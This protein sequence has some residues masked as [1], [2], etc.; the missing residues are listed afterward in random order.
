VLL[1]DVLEHFPNE[2]Q[3]PLLAAI[4][5]SLV[6][7]GRLIVKTPNANSIVASRWRYTRRPTLRFW[8]SKFFVTDW[9]RFLIR[10]FWLQ[11]FKAEFPQENLAPISF[12]ANLQA[13][14]HKAK[15][16]GGGQDNVPA[17]ALE[18][19]VAP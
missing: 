2:Q 9:R 5:R 18:E 1:L 11:V 16:S 14:A 15:Q 8:R 6:P 12:E 17:P 19:R 3:I 13:V 10:W 7:G 4:H